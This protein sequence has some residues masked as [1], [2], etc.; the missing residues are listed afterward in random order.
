MGSREALADD[1]AA[2]AAVILEQ[3]LATLGSR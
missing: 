1:D 2:A 3:Y